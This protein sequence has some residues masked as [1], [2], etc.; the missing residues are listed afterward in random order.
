MVVIKLLVLRRS[1]V[2][3]H[4]FCWIFTNV[5]VSAIGIALIAII[6]ER[7]GRLLRFSI[8]IFKTH[9]RARYEGSDP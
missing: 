9:T 3:Y 4:L 8:S 1:V 5:K 6:K 2:I 7:D